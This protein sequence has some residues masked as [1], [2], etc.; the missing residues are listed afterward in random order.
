MDSRFVRKGKSAATHRDIMFF[1]KTI[2]NSDWRYN[3]IMQIIITATVISDAAA[4][5]SK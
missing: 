4:E 5:W 1:I 2:N 3:P